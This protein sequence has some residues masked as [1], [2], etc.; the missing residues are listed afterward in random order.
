MAEPCPVVAQGKAY[1]SIREAAKSIGITER[2]AYRNLQ[3]KGHLEEAG[4]ARFGNRNAK[5]T[6]VTIYGLRFESISEAGRALGM[7]RNSVRRALSAGAS[8]ADRERLYVACMRI[9]R[10][11]AA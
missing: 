8:Q 11:G 3:I 4:H 2:W 6:P 5:R 7:N 9:T 1:P 10:T